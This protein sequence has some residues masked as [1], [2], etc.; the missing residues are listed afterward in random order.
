MK[1]TYDTKADVLRI[2]LNTTPIEGSDEREP[3]VIFDYDKNGKVVG[4]EILDA[5]LRTDDPRTM[6]FAVA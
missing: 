6:E 3:G 2:I 1:V 5:S 4:I